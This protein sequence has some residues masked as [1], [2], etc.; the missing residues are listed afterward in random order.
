M[1]ICLCGP[2]RWLP[3]GGWPSMKGQEC[4]IWLCHESTPRADIALRRDESVPAYRDLYQRM[5]SEILSGRLAAGARLPSSRTLAS[6]LGVARGTVEVA[7]QMLAGEGY[8]IGDGARGTIVNPALPRTRS[9][10]HSGRPPSTIR[11]PVASTASS[12]RR[13]CS[14]WDCRR[15]TCSRA[16]NGRRSPRGSHDNSISSK[17]P[18]RATSIR[19]ATSR[20][21]APLR[22]ICG[23]HAIFR[24]PPS[25][26]DY[27]GL[28]GSARLIV[29]GAARAGRQGVG[30]GSGYFQAHWLLRQ[31]PLRLVG[32][33]G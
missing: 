16:S 31:A 7:Y 22:A 26:S 5:R 12:R 29:T 1:S 10:R 13:C 17:W 23:S 14:K 2:R 11:K 19:W 25:K 6:Q 27:G 28:P 9:R 15:S 32:R 3:N 33:A 21:D 4:E 20:C 24:A 18:I 8:T 30:R